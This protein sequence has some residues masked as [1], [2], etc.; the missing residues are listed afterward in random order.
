MMDWGSFFI[1]LSPIFLVLAAIEIYYDRKERK[2]DE[3]EDE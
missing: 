3:R 1:F 2:F